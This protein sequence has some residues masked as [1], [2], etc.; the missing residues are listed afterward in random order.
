MLISLYEMMLGKHLAQATN[1]LNKRTMGGWLSAS[2]LLMFALCS[3]AFALPVSYT[4]DNLNRL[5]EANYNSGQ[6]VITYKYD[7]AGNILS[8]T[9]AVTEQ[10]ADSDGDGI[11]DV[12]EMANFGNLTTANAT[13][14][15]D[16]D[17]LLDIDEYKDGTDPNNKDTDGDGFSDGE[18]VRDGSNPLMINDTPNNHRPYTPVILPLSAKVALH[19]QAFDTQNFAD[20][21]QLQGD[22]LAA[23]RWEV[24]TDKNFSKGHIV[25]N[26]ILKKGTNDKE[27][28]YRRLRIPDDILLKATSY[29]VRTRHQDRVGLWSAWSVS[30]PFSTLA[31]DPN[32]KDNNGIDD[33]HQVIGY[34]DTNSNG[35]DDSKEGIRDLYEA[36]GSTTV[37]MHAGSGTLGGITAVPDTDIP[38]ALMPAN[39]MTYGLFS[40]RVDGLPV[41][42][43]NPATT[44]V[45]FYFPKPLPS[46]T[47]WYKY[48]PASNTMTDFTANVA[49]TGNQATVTLTDGGAGD[50]DG[51]INGV[52]VDPSGPTLPAASSTGNGNGSSNGNTNA[53]SS[54]GGGGGGGGGCSLTTDKKNAIDP[55]LPLLLLWSLAYLMR[56]RRVR[57]LGKRPPSPGA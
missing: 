5:T 14:D 30:V 3:Q 21:D 57:V 45:T 31:T 36:Q 33:R 56:R 20:P 43:A 52:I 32:D 41:D 26:K 2:L 1:N 55:V 8:K 18:E 49:F 22:Y 47:K 17:G 42:A 9:I 50:A 44:D 23:S 7:A 13:T 6:Q 54:G 11:P 34:T 51:V 27:V 10:H 38:S 16:G 53:A 15:T 19:A 12:W 35:I 4:Y 25:F 40:F 48:D 39:A 28:D 24:S 29:W 37:G 46:G